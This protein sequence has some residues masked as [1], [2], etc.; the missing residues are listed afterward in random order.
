ME[1]QYLVCTAD[2]F[3]LALPVNEAVEEAHR[4]GMLTSASLMVTAPAADDAV[5]RAKRLPSLGVGLH[6]TLVDGR[7]AL[8]PEEIPDLVTS[9][10]RLRLDLATLGTRI[11]FQPHVRHQ[12]E[13]EIRAQITRFLATGLKLDH[14][15][16]HHHFHQHP[17][18]VGMLARMAKEYDIRSVRLPV[19]PP[20]YSWRAQQNRPLSRLAAWLFSPARL[21]GMRRRLGKAGIRC[22]DHVFGLHE[23]GDMIPER[24]KGFLSALPPGVTEIY[25]HPATRPWESPDAL[26]ADYC[27]VEEFLAMTDPELLTL[28]E[29]AS[30]QRG[31]FGGIHAV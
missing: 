6:L 25:F 4:H 10:G 12:V 3:G 17:T 20:F 19:E 23:S 11:F 13:R 16:G 31:T 9:D 28:V 2:D 5:E 30:L 27:C 18:I 24:L 15:D 7:P 14:I 29:Q 26:P 21:F 22:N 8:P 1:S